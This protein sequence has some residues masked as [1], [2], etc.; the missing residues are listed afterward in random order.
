MVDIKKLIAMG[1]LGG[2]KTVPIPSPDFSYVPFTIQKQ[3]KSFRV[4]PSF[5][6]LAYSGISGRA[7]YVDPVNGNDGNNGLSWNAP[8]RNLYA[9]AAKADVVII[10]C[11]PGEY[12]FTANKGGWRGGLGNASA[13][14]CVG[15]VATIN[16]A[17]SLSYTTED[18]HYKA[19]ITTEII[20]VFDNANIDATGRMLSYT[21][22]TSVEGVDATAGSWWWSSNTLYVHT[23]DNRVPDDNI[24][25]YAVTSTGFSTTTENKIIYL[26]NIKFY[27][28]ADRLV[29]TYANG[30]GILTAYFKGCTFSNCKQYDAFD[31]DGN[32]VAILQDCIAE[33]SDFDGF[34]YH[35]TPFTGVPRVIEI[36]CEGRHNGITGSTNNGSSVHEGILVTRIGGKYHD[37]FGANIGDVGG[38]KSW[39]LGSE[40]YDSKTTTANR[41]C[42]FLVANGGATEM[43]C[44]TC[45]SHGNTYDLYAEIQKIYKRDMVGASEG[46]ASGGTITAY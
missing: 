13:L 31:V 37:N 26:E 19:T 33:C 6:L 17:H 1:V 44:D 23:A 40:S 45:I 14:I 20:N 39:N 46:T 35:V 22:K 8:L 5:N 25:P 29:R 38:A 3:G 21:K 27:G 7:Y 32:V 43:W 11:V 9:A 41:N 15:G 30:A 42:G 2:W 12:W 4:N 10:Y 36:N 18:S 34:N 16:N 24:R 28:T